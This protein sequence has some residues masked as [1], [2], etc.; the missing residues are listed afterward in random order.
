[1]MESMTQNRKSVGVVLYREPKAETKNAKDGHGNREYLLLHYAAGHWDF[2]KGGQEAGETDEQTLRRELQEETGINNVEL[3][4][5]VIHE[6]SYFFREQGKLIRKTVVF[7]LSQTTQADVKL[8]FEHTDFAWLPYE[9]AMAQ[10]T[11]KNAKELL[12]KADEYLSER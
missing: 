8:S 6:L 1:M 4:P 9:N 5:G 2:P 10:L 11:H 3:V 7:Y 12:E